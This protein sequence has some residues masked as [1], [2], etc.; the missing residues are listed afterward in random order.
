[1]QKALSKADR[2]FEFSESLVYV[3]ANLDRFRQP[4][5]VPTHEDI[6]HVRQRT[7]GISETRFKVDKGTWTLIDVGG[8]KVERRKWIHSQASETLTA[9][10]FVAALDEYDIRGE[11]EEKTGS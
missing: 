4:D 8:Q 3:M 9:V 6:V 7:T 5:W 10:L 2:K 1:V 11:D